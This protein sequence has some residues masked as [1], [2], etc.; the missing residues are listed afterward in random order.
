MN[1]E[2]AADI[3]AIWKSLSFDC[4][5]IRELKLLKDCAIKVT[6]SDDLRALVVGK[7]DQERFFGAKDEF[8]GGEAHGDDECSGSTCRSMTHSWR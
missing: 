6:D 3:H 5:K 1:M 8:Y 7:I 4:R 2:G